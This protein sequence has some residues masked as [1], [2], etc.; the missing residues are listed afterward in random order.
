MQL[1]SIDL[2]PTT[3]SL[4]CGQ[5]YLESGPRGLG[6]YEAWRRPGGMG[7]G[8]RIIDVEYGWTLDHEDLPAT[9]H[10]SGHNS[11]ASQDHGSAVPGLA[12]SV[13]RIRIG[14]CSGGTAVGDS[15]V[16]SWSKAH[17]ASRRGTK[18]PSV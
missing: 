15:A 1:L 17:A 6:A 5:R 14:G 9:F 16:R 12:N 8:V 7:A 11:L 3:A 18:L 13:E 10:L 4:V 2:T